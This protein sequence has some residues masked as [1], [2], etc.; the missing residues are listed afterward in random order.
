MT[1]PPYVA[2]DGA[3][4]DHAGAPSTSWIFKH[5]ST[6]RYISCP[7]RIAISVQRL[8]KLIGA[9]RG[10]LR[11]GDARQNKSIGTGIGV[12]VIMRNHIDIVIACV[13]IILAKID[14]GTIAKFRKA[15]VAPNPGLR[16]II[17]AGQLTLTAIG[18]RIASPQIECAIHHQHARR[19]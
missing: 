10:D 16:M 2:P 18:A 19:L 7:N 3:V 15:P 1:L 13:R 9:A 8:K 14:K 4:I 12:G 6:L 17:R 5:E 11:L